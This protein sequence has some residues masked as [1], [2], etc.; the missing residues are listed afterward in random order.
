[1]EEGWAEPAHL[2]LFKM[3]PLRGH[4]VLEVPMRLGLTMVERLLGGAGSTG[5]VTRQLSDIENG[6]LEQIV[7]VILSHWFG[8]WSK[9]KDV[10]PI[11]LGYE[12]SGRFLQTTAPQ[13]NML[14]V[15]LSVNIAELQEEMQIVLP[16]LSLEPLIRQLAQSGEASQEAPAPPPAAACKWNPCFDEISVCVSANW[17]Q[18]EVATG[19]VL[20]L[21]VGDVLRVNPQCAQKVTVRVG[22]MPKFNGRLGTC[23]GKWAVELTQAI[24]S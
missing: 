8:H 19:D 17:P 14:A 21:K 22:E 18:L 16:Y 4:G 23:G 5:D 3:E 10:K 20:Q 13:T 2:T 15:C 1:L 11:I 9:F 12:T 6:L 7:Q 24:K